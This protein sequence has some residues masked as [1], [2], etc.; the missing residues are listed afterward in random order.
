MRAFG[1]ARLKAAIDEVTLTI[2]Q[3]IFQTAFH[4][5]N[6]CSMPPAPDDVVVT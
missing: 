6:H 5:V 3:S 2:S 4:Q 1:P